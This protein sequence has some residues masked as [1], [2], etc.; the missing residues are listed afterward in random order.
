MVSQFWRRFVPGPARYGRKSTV[1]IIRAMAKTAIFQ[2]SRRCLRPGYPSG[3]MSWTHMATSRRTVSAFDI[4]SFPREFRCPVSGAIPPSL[5][6][7]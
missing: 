3:L 4:R 5:F 1:T 2:K 7:A 6:V